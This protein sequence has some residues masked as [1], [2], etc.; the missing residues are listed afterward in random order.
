MSV[1]LAYK[2][3]LG[4]FKQ[5][6][7]GS[8]LGCLPEEFKSIKWN[9]A[10]I[11]PTDY[12]FTNFQVG[13]TTVE[14]TEKNT[15]TQLT[16]AKKYDS[17]TVT[18]PT[19]SFATLLPADAESIIDQLDALTDVDDP[20]KVLLCAGVYKSDS[21]GTRTY[22]VFKSC[23]AILT[24]DGGRS[25]EAKGTFS[26]TLGLQACHLPI[27]GTV[28]CAATMTWNTSTGAVNLV[29]TVSGGNS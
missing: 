19:F 4:L 17:G 22:D 10:S 3:C 11:I 13:D 8:V 14:T 9:L 26:G 15:I 6:P 7:S 12:D 29:P 16:K 28:K 20:Y 27:F 5:D 24:T 2:L 25:G 21:N 23:A 1:E 18:P